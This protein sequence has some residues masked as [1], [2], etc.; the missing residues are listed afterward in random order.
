MYAVVPTFINEIAAWVGA[1]VVISGGLTA[2]FTRKPFKWLG[3]RLFTEPLGGWLRHQINTSETG[4]LVK[5]HLGP[6]GTTP[7]M[8]R[9]I[10]T[11]EANQMRKLIDE[12]IEL[13]SED[14]A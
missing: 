5:Y 4:H 3:R 1:I 12:F 13:E 9:R 11:L 8:H 6:N 7:P 14:D 10:E 2:I